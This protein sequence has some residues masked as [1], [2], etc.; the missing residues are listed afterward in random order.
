[1]SSLFKD[2]VSQ[3]VD[4]NGKARILNYSISRGG[5]ISLAVS[6]IPPLKILI[7][8]KKDIKLVPLSV[9]TDFIKLKSLL[10]VEQDGNKDDG[11]QGIWVETQEQNSGIYYGYIP[12]NPN[13]TIIANVPFSQRNDPI[14]TD[15]PE[16]SE[17]TIFRRDRKIA[18]ILKQYVLFTYALNPEDFDEN[19]FWIDPEHIYDIEKLN[20]KLYMEGNDIIY[21]DGYIVVVSEEIRDGLMSFLKVSLL[22][23]TPG[24]MATANTKIIE[25]YYQIISDFRNI[26]D[27]L[28]F[29]N[30]NGLKRWKADMTKSFK[31]SIISSFPLEDAKDPYYYKNLKIRRDN[32]MIVQN[33]AGGTLQEAISVS[34]KWN[35][36][37][38][39][40]GFNI[41]VSNII[42]NISYVLYTEMGEIAREKKKTNFTN[43]FQYENGSHA[44]LLFFI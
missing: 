42:D 8:D 10:I 23:D 25:N 28:I 16:R 27:Q 5:Q 18:E 32:L 4:N 3:Y 15:S 37:R 24:V 33:V 38:I 30:K 21:R 39:N 41:P 44:A 6:P 13:K 17:L 34:Y 43:V 11:I 40:S 26:H 12:I 14:R 35:T 7:S 2:V 1:M 22:N 19:Y 9:A 20:K 36:S 31:G 29:V